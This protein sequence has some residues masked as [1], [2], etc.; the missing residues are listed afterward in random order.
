MSTI[1]ANKALCNKCSYLG[2][3]RMNR[4]ID[5]LNDINKSLKYNTNYTKVFTINR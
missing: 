5:A 1:Y 3:Q 2:Y 4:L